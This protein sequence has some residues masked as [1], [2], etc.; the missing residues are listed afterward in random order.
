[1]SILNE[2]SKEESNLLQ[3]KN[4]H[5]PLETDTITSKSFNSLI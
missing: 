1:M 4:L 5:V 3:K 2:K